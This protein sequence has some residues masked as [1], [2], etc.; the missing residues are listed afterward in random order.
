VEVL[1]AGQVAGSQQVNN[2]N[3]DKEAIINVP[4][5]LTGIP[6][7]QHEVVARFILQ[8]NTNSRTEASSGG[9]VTFDFSPPT[10]T[11]G[12]QPAQDVCYQNGRVPSAE[13]D[14]EDNFDNAPQV[15]QT[16]I[17]DG[18]GRTLQVVARD[19]CGREASA[20]RDYRVGTA[21]NLIVDGVEEG[22]LS[23]QAQVTWAVDGLAACANNIE[24]SLS[25]DGGAPV[26]YGENNLINTPG[27]Y[28]LRLTVWN[29]VGA[30]R[31]QVVNFR[32]N[33]PPVARPRPDGHPNADP[34]AANAYIVAEGSPLT[35]DGMAST[36]P[37]FD[38]QVVAYQWT[39]PGQQALQ[40]PSPALNTNE[41]GVFNGT[42]QVTDSLGATHSESVQVTIT[43]IDP[44]VN[45]GGPYVADQ[46]V[47]I[48]FDASRSRSTNPA[49]DPITSYTWSWDDG[50]QDSAGVV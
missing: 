30:P 39:I 34:N 11:F 43:D 12:A 41:D 47:P 2:Y 15:S 10:I 42:L 38:D 45:A 8:S 21:V 40:G 46:G 17:E 28:T 44:I 23:N 32:V 22:A 27:D 1:V 31:D 29:C 25:R 48:R 13:V 36:S 6:E 37:E 26:P 35:L 49:A 16:V 4:L 5:N 14:V 24:A 20:E 19:R 9:R 7:G 50:T 3:A 18:C 33:R